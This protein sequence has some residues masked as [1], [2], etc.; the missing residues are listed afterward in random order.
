[1]QADDGEQH[2]QQGACDPSDRP[3][4]HDL[5]AGHGPRGR[6][7]WRGQRVLESLGRGPHEHYL[8]AQNRIRNPASQH[9]NVGDLPKMPWG[10]RY[11]MRTR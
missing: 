4:G 11:G 2:G 1:M 7:D 9:I 3:D 10:P 5:D 6:R 8:P